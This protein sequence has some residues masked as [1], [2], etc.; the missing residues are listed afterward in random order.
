M[1]A[2][3]PGLLHPVRAGSGLPRDRRQALHGPRTRPVPVG[4]QQRRR[5]LRVV[6]PDAGRPLLRMPVMKA[7]PLPMKVC[8]REPA[9]GEAV[10]AVRQGPSLR[11][12]RVRPC[13]WLPRSTHRHRARRRRSGSSGRHEGTR[14]RGARA[15]GGGEAPY[16]VTVSTLAKDLSGNRPG[17]SAQAKAQEHRIDAPV[18][19]LLARLMGVHTD[20]RAWRVGARG[21]QVVATVSRRSGPPGP[22]CTTCRS[23]TAAPTS[24]TW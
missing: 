2:G 21:E 15:A 13:A 17:A 5:R 18:R 7:C 3:V 12:R 6:D 10:E 4:W 20:E 19:T 1:H 9:V 11:E 8:G 22:R 14:P 16:A 23:E 24:T